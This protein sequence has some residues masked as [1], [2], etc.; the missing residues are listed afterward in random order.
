MVHGHTVLPTAAT[1]PHA[2]GE[3]FLQVG[4]VKTAFQMANMLRDY[5]KCCVIT[6][7]PW[8]KKIYNGQD[9]NRF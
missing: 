9:L 8:G 7:D 5:S 3:H 4:K 6:A 1:I 2:P